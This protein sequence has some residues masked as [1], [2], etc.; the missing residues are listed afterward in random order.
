MDGRLAVAFRM[1][2]ISY[3]SILPPA[4]DLAEMNPIRVSFNRSADLRTTH[5]LKIATLYCPN[6]LESVSNQ[7]RNCS[8]CCNRFPKNRAVG[9]RDQPWK[10]KCI[11]SRAPKS[12]NSEII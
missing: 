2:A 7:K 10:R 1:V 9:V 4:W 6:L 5:R 8:I 11:R 3:H 12:G